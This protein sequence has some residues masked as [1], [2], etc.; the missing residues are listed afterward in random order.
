MKIALHNS[1]ARK[2]IEEQGELAQEIIIQVTKICN[3]FG[4]KLRFT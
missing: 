1:N 3:K 4:V 2:K